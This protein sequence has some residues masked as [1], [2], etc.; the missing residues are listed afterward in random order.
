M[1]NRAVVVKVLWEANGQAPYP[2]GDAVVELPGGHVMFY[3]AF[4]GNYLD[5]PYPRYSGEIPADV[6]AK[7]GGVNPFV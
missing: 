4:Y 2:H 3:G 6:S 1:S 5:H 7:I